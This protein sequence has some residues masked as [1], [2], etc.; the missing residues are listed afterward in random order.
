MSLKKLLSNYASYNLWANTTLVE[1]LKTKPAATWDTEVPS[2]FSSIT[3][4]IIHIWDTERFWNAVLKQLP[5]PP[6]FRYV[7]YEGTPEEAMQELI[8]QS[9]EIEAYVNSLSEEACADIRDLDTPWVKGALP[10]YEFIQHMI[11]HS[12]YHRG[13]LITIGRNAGLE[14][15][16]MTDYNFF[17]M[18]VDKSKR[19]NVREAA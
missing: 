19:K 5:A 16:P 18:A 14:D 3:K 11:N 12:T 8:R 9:E 6:S 1:W 13:Q 10:Q 7:K 2:S 4:T 17:N 15:A